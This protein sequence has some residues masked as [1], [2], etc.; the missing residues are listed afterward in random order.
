[1]GNVVG[2]NIANVLLILGVSAL[3]IPLAVAQQ[4]IRLD[5]PL[6]IG[7]SVLVWLMSFDG[8]INRLDGLVLAAGGIIYTI[9][10]IW[11]SR[12]E[13]KAVRQEFERQFG[14][15]TS[16]GYQQLA[17]QIGLVIAGL[18][19]LVIGANWLVNGAVIIANYFGVSE[20]IIGLTIVAVGTSLPEAATSVV[21]AMRGERDIAVG[22][23][24]GS[25]IFN[26]LIVLGFTSVV[27]VN[28]IN[29]SLPA[30]YFSIP[31]MIAVAIACLPVFFT[32][33]LIARWEGLLFLG[34]YIAYIG[35]LLL[36]A[37]QS[38]AIEP[39]TALIGIVLPLTAITLAISVLRNVITNRQTKQI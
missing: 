22:N 37:T 35:Y 38:Q 14:T 25:N 8:V 36:S 31:V 3:I 9:F 15:K 21:A 12:K 4:L 18:I 32:G 16:P 10:A 5:V 34:Y 6:M 26:I 1:M 28:G 7:L 33:N 27:A 20:L 19:L 11:Q 39:F 29:V 2:S 30:F 24:I 13:S 17:L 23:I